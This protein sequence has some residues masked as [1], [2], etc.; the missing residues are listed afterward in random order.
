MQRA[1][2]NSAAV[3][4]A[5]A[6]CAE[7]KSDANIT[8]LKAAAARESCVVDRGQQLREPELA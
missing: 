6:L 7:G 1:L 2:P 8:E 5:L 3:V 4:A